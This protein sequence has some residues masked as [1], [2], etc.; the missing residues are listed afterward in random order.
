MSQLIDKCVFC[1]FTTTVREHHIVP[2]AKGGTTTVLC[3]E[4]CESFLHKT[5][6]H[7]ELRDVYNNVETIL[8]NEAFQ[9]FLKW[10]KK[11]SPDTLFKSDRGNNRSKRKYS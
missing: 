2:R 6:S 11:Q 9:R 3:C 10:R 4:T 5:W 1:G 8:A 7:N